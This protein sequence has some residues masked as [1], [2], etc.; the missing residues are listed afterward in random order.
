MA[1]ISMVNRYMAAAMDATSS[2]DFIVEMITESRG[3]RSYSVNSFPSSLFEYL[4]RVSITDTGRKIGKY[5]G[6]TVAQ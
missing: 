1:C 4:Y 5:S 3:L 6:W 2:P